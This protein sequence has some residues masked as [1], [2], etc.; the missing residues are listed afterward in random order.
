MKK[1]HFEC[2]R[3][4]VKAGT[5]YRTDYLSS[6]PVFSGV[7]IAQS[8]IYVVFCKSVFVRLSFSVSHY[9]ACR[10]SSIYDF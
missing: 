5:A 9:I 1:L 2:K 3:Q 4:P 7:C 8:L 6:L 10:L